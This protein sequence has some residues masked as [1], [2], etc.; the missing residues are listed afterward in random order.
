MAGS[1]REAAAN[2]KGLQEVTTLIPV[3]RDTQS[4]DLEDFSHR[5]L[6]QP[7]NIPLLLPEKKKK[8]KKKLFYSF[9]LPVS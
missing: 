7:V 9:L 1:L 3:A 6:H 4:G 8:E 5:I 2:L